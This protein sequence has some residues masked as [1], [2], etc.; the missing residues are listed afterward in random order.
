MPRPPRR[1]KQLLF[2]PSGLAQAG[3]EPRH[4]ALSKGSERR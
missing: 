4:S 1:E 2:V 3:L